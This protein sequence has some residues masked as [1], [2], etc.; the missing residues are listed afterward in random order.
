MK[1]C[2]VDADL[3]RYGAASV[4]T[5]TCIALLRVSDTSAACITTAH[6][7]V[8][9]ELSAAVAALAIVSRNDTAATDHTQHSELVMVTM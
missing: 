1:F 2:S 3:R 8:L 7:S 9:A 6:S 5:L 4:Q